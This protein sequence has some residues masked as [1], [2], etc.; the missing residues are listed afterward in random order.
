MGNEPDVAARAAGDGGVG[1][2]L[3]R[4]IIAGARTNR[5]RLLEVA[6]HELLLLGTRGKIPCPALGTQWESLITAPRGAHSEKPECVLEMIEAYFPNLPKIELNRRG[7]ARPGW[8]AWGN[9]FEE[10]AA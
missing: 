3:R 7:P 6:E 10:A 8:D 9:E 2:R 4:P 5:H 1:F